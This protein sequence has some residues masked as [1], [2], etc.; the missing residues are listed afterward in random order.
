M[1]LN[2]VNQLKFIGKSNV[3][4]L[5]PLIDKE[6]NIQELID[7]GFIKAEAKQYEKFSEVLTDKDLILKIPFIKKVI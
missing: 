1:V 2:T 4:V 7:L 5:K 6:Y 3:D